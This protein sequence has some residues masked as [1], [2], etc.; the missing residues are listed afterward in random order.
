LFA[1]T[2]ACGAEAPI[3]VDVAESDHALTKQSQAGLFNEETGGY[4]S[5][6]EIA[7]NATA[8]CAAQSVL[9]SGKGKSVLVK[10]CAGKLCTS[11][12]LSSLT[13]ADDD[14]IVA[15]SSLTLG[16]ADAEPGEIEPIEVDDLMYLCRE[17]EKESVCECIP[18]FPPE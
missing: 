12:P 9:V 10:S 7:R 16:A 4:V 3:D 17:D 14:G 5:T 13:F 15:A 8:G 6:L 11:T 1:A 2:S 18:W